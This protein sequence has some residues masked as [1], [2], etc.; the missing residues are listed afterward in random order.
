MDEGTLDK[1]LEHLPEH[2]RKIIKDQLLLPPVDINY[3]S[4]YRY[5]TTWDLVILAVAS[6]S[7]IAAG[8]AMPFFTVSSIPFFLCFM[9]AE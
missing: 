5:A 2:E 7:T 1:E 3:F 6:V 4:L 8:A 9:H